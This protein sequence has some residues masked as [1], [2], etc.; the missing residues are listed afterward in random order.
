MGDSRPPGS[1]PVNLVNSYALRR[2]GQVEVVLADPAPPLDS[3][4]AVMFLRAGPKRV[5]SRASLVD[6]ARGRRLVASFP[7][8]DLADGQYRVVVRVSDTRTRPGVRLL[9]Q[10]ERPVVLLWGDRPARPRAEA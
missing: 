4:D 5:R 2:A 10:G 9:V 8:D 1:A 7:D 6:D 3:D